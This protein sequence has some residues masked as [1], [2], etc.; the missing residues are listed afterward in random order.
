MPM[1]A[2]MKLWIDA[3]PSGLVWTGLDCDDDLAILAASALEAAE[4]VQIEGLSICGGNAPLVHTWP[5]A[6][7]LMQT[8][9]SKWNVSKGAGWRKMQP[10]WASL[11]LLSHLIWEEESNDAAEAIVAAAAALPPGELTVLMLGPATNLARA[12]QLAPWL[13]GHLKAAVLMG[14]ELTG[15]RLDLNFMSDRAAARSVIS[16][17]LPTVLIPIQTC[18][19]AAITAQFV[20][21]LAGCTSPVEAI[22]P[23]MRQQTWLMPSLVNRRVRLAL[24]DRPQSEFLAEGFIPWDLVALLAAVRPR[25]FS[26]WE[27]FEVALPPC[28]QE[29]CDGTMQSRLTSARGAGVVLVPQLV[30]EGLL[31]EDIFQLLCSTPSS[32]PTP[33]P[34]LGFVPQLLLLLLLVLAV[35]LV[36]LRLLR[37]LAT[38]SER[39]TKQD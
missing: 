35:F 9:P 19:Q 37:T 27:H 12:L 20:E 21:R 38:R 22:L 13:A 36:L 26:R 15:R 3:D 1:K 33:R 34:Q 24:E 5:N 6:Q 32:G 16:S 4:E 31:L 10:A 17:E 11:R 23:K 28:L 7:R 30:D 2:A 8:I 14:G 29:P 25:R 18:A 39:I